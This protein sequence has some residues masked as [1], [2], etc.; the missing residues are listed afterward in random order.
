MLIALGVALAASSA[1]PPKAEAAPVLKVTSMGSPTAA[2]KKEARKINDLKMAGL[3]PQCFRNKGTAL[4]TRPQD[5]S[6]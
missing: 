4:K 1:E 5:H 2:K 6:R 3:V